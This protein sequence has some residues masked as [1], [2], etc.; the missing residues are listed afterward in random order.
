MMD[1][2]KAFTI[3]ETDQVGDVDS[4]AAIVPEPRNN[5][6]IITM[7]SDDTSTIATA[8]SPMKLVSSTAATLSKGSSSKIGRAH[9]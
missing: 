2:C 6:P 8:A 7:D 4:T 3:D 1:E 9:V 5:Q